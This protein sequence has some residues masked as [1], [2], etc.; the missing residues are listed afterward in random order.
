MK[1]PAQKP[2]IKNKSSHP[3]IS[4]LKV[5]QA[6]QF[7]KISPSTLRRYEDEGKILSQRDKINNYRFYRVE[8]VRKLKKLLDTPVVV[9]ANAGIQLKLLGKFKGGKDYG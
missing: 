6:A 3:D 1:R 7:L 2:Y 4:G 9:S 5:S 8:D